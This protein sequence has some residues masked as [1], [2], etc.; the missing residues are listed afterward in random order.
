MPKDEKDVKSKTDK[1]TK[2]K[3]KGNE[4]RIF[5]ADGTVNQVTKENK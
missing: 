2:I 5:N 4:I 1:P 3:Q